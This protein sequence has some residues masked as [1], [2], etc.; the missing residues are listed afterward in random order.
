M[1]TVQVPGY[2]AVE[3]MLSCWSGLLAW[4]SACTGL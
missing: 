2:K 3:A 1:V 4:P